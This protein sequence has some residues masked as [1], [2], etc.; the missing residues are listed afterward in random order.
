MDN[1][2]HHKRLSLMSI[3]E[4]RRMIGDAPPDAALID[5][6]QSDPRAGVRALVQSI[7][8]R[9]ERKNRIEAKH[10]EMLA[11]E[12]GLRANGSRYIAGVDEAGRGPLAGPVS[13]GSVILPENIHLPGLDDSKKM[14]AKAREEMYARIAEEAVAWSVVMLDHLEIDELGIQGAIMEG[15][16][17]AV[18]RLGVPPDTALIDGRSLPRTDVPRAG[19]RGR[20]PPCAS[21]SRRHRSWPRSPATVSW[22]KWTPVIPDTGSRVTRD[23]AARNMSKLCDAVA[24]APSTVFP[25]APSPR[26]PLPARCVRRSNKGCACRR[27]G[28]P[29]PRGGGDPAQRRAFRRRDAGIPARCFP[30]MPG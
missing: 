15:M 6:L 10:E 21:P 16:R 1:P 17:Q 19:H 18:E 7:G 28:R 12:R 2:F 22:W 9:L 26:F 30:G 8:K 13:L 25:T 29:G 11:I 20:R 24:P 5:R 4:I 3:T 23:M 14:S 27:P